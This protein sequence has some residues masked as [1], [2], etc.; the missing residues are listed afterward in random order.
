VT[1]VAQEPC[2]PDP[3]GAGALDTERGQPAV[4]TYVTQAEGEQMLEPSLVACSRIVDICL[5]TFIPR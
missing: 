3:A 5:M 1:V 4:L 2:Q